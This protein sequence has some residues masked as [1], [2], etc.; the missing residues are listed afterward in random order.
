MPPPDDGVTDEAALPDYDEEEA[1]PEV[2]ANEEYGTSATCAADGLWERVISI[3]LGSYTGWWILT[4]SKWDGKRFV[5]YEEQGIDVPEVERV[6]TMLRVTV[7][8]EPSITR[9]RLDG[10]RWGLRTNLVMGYADC[11]TDDPGDGGT[12]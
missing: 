10:W 5:S 8:T 11:S 6:G 9:F 7:M 1:H 12:P 3:D 4:L 2:Y